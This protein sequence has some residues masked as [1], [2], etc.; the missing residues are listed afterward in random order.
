MTHFVVMNFNPLVIWHNIIGITIDIDRTEVLP[1]NID[2]ADGS[3]KLFANPVGMTH[4][5][6]MNF[7]PLDI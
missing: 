2:R 4:F 5:V 3:H 1:L 7:N 6:A